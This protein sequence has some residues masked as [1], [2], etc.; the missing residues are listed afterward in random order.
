MPWAPRQRCWAG[1]WLEGAESVLVG[2]V[3]YAGRYGAKIQPGQGYVSPFAQV[4]DY[5]S[6]V[7]QKLEAL[8]RYLVQLVPGARFTT[9]V[10]SG[11]GCERIFAALAGVGWQGK[12]NFIIVP[13][14]GSFVWLG[15][16]TT[17]VKLPPDSPLASQC[18]DCQRCLSACPTQAYT[19][20]NDFDHNQC[21]A[22]WA[23]AKG[24]LTLRQEQILGRHRIVYGCDYCQLACPHN[25]AGTAA[26]S[27][28]DIAEIMTM[29][30]SQ[31]ETMFRDSAAGWRGRNLLRRNAVLASQGK[32]E[33]RAVL[34]KLAQ[35]RG[36]VAETARRVLEDDLPQG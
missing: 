18:G 26:G 16:L 34:E 9:Q 30:A 28:P 5:H 11:P 29:S 8:G 25:E 7:R 33:F 36:M 6:L 35:G 10:D 24:N 12:N 14:H 23:V 1:D 31:F 15:L 27:M 32:P 3:S 19:D 2:A 4:P 13:G 17:N 20:A 21:L 22:Y